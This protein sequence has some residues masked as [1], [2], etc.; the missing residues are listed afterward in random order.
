MK[1]YVEIRSARVEDAVAI[2]ECVVA[3]YE[4]YTARLGK[5]AGPMLDDYERVIQQHRVLVLT[6]AT[7]II[8]ILVLVTQ[9]ESLLI[10]NVAVHPDH[11]G[12]GLGRRLMALADE[13]ARRLGFTT[14]NLYTNE[15]MTENI[16]LYKKLGY[17]ETERK[18]EKGYDRI[19]M[20]K[21]LDEPQ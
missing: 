17:T 19:Y 12:R 10:D 1:G 2:T 13:E 20:R 21:S 14:V 3:A 5:P 4:N 6:E 8:G 15:R 18:T 7:R 9:N 11:Q 16:E